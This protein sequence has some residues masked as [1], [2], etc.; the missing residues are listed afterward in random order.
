MGP[1][2]A[3]ERSLKKE[4]RREERLQVISWYTSLLYRKLKLNMAVVTT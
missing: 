1:S 4:M 2:G 3:A